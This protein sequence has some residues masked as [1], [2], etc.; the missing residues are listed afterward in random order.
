MPKDAVIEAEV[1]KEAN[2]I[3]A[4][5]DKDIAARLHRKTRELE[6]AL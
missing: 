3:V 5:G 1:I 6:A 4:A 2:K